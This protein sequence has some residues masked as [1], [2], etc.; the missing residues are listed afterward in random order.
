MKALGGRRVGVAGALAGA[1]AVL[2]TTIT[3]LAPS[4]VAADVQ[5]PQW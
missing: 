1:M 3:G 5:A 4:A 2:V